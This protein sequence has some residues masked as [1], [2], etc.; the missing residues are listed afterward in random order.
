M[1]RVD[2]GEAQRAQYKSAQKNTERRPRV[3]PAFRHAALAINHKPGC[4]QQRDRPCH[5][6]IVYPAV[7][8]VR[9]QRRSARHGSKCHLMQ[10]VAQNAADQQCSRNEQQIPPAGKRSA[11][12]PPKLQR[13]EQAEQRRK[14]LRHII[15][16][17]QMASNGIVAE[18]AIL[19]RA[20]KQP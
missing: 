11:L 1:K 15:A 4:Q 19:D 10:V 17:P 3:S 9:L 13:S 5:G 6:K 12:P 2:I 18:K 8:I 16:I 20:Q 14:D 7:G